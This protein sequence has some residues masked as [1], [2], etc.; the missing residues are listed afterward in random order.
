MSL[1]WEIELHILTA[2]ESVSKLNSVAVV[3]KRTILIER[4]LLVGEVSV[5]LCG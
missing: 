4:P 2:E 3:C 1:L 5:N